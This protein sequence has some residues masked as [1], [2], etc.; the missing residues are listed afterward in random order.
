MI[1][2]SLLRALDY[3]QLTPEE[4]N[5]IRQKLSAWLES[6]AIHPAKKA[7]VVAFF[8]FAFEDRSPI[9]FPALINDLLKRASFPLAFASTT[10]KEEE[11]MAIRS[12]VTG[13]RLYRGM[14]PLK[15]KINLAIT[16]DEEVELLQQVLPL[17]VISFKTAEFLLKA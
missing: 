11:M 6:E 2:I 5:L 13:E 1:K 3:V 4:L 8:S 16:V 12:S 14:M 9:A 10:L 15:D 7:E 17:P